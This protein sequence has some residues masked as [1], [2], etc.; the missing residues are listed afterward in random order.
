MQPCQHGVARLGQVPWRPRWPVCMVQ[1]GGRL[2]QRP[3]AGTRVR[4]NGDAD[5]A[6]GVKPGGF[7]LGVCLHGS[8]IY[9]V[10]TFGRHPNITA[11]GCHVNGG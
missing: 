2:T 7:T 10:A 3:S 1:C 4:G 6:Q 9:G 5:A 11:G 8:R